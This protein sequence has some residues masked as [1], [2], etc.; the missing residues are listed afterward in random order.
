M[1]REVLRMNHGFV[2]AHECL[3]YSYLCPILIDSRRRL[4]PHKAK[5]AGQRFADRISVPQIKQPPWNR[6]SP[7]KAFE[8]ESPQPLDRIVVRRD[9]EVV[10]VHGR[11]GLHESANEGFTLTE[12]KRAREA[13]IV[14]PHLALSRRWQRGIPHHGSLEFCVAI[15]RRALMRNR[16][17]AS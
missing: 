13:E 6:R 2:L 16:F 3:P 9:G 1:S 10:N 11:V 12:F 17:A 4:H 5:P 7:S 8:I 14:N 15:S